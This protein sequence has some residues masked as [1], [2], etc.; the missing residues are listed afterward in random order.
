M[1]TQLILTLL[2]AS[3]ITSV[4]A[5]DEPAKAIS[6]EAFGVFS[7]EDAK[8]QS[9]K[10]KNPLVFLLINERSEEPKV[11]ETAKLTYW[12]LE[13]D[14]V[15]V[16]LRPNTAGEW[17][18]RLPEALPAAINSAEMGKEYPRLVAMDQSGSVVLT[19]VPA[20][21]LIDGGE[22]YIK[23]LNKELKELNKNPPKASASAPAT[24]TTPATPG[25]APTPAAAAV[26]AIAGGSV[27]G[28][29]NTEGRTIQATLIAV[30]A[31]KVTFQMPNGAKV[32][33]PLANLNDASKKR[34]DEL[35]AA[36][37]K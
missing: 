28:W 35:K 27:E 33:Y 5:R 22:D 31:D 3:V 26:V 21:K 13:K 19:S 24:P 37:S 29:T 20:G 23:G 15:V 9:E 34:V 7:F 10:K 25:A 6:K 8:K 2:A 30:H 14:N 1:K 11:E 17:K 12:G 32:D 16:V 18:R 4:M 36:S